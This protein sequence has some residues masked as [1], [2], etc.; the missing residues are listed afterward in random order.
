MIVESSF[1]Q[2]DYLVN[3]KIVTQRVGCSIELLRGLI[4]KNIKRC[5]Y[6]KQHQLMKDMKEK[7]L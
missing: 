5:E 6:D 7:E 2:Y 4:E 1:A 3:G